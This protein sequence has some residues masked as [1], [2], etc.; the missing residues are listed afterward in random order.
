MMSYT[1]K[2]SFT[3]NIS[4]RFHYVTFAIKSQST[5][6]KRL[7]AS[8]GDIRNAYRILVGKLTKTDHLVSQGEK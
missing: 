8:M 2:P 3:K 6:W 7:V 4:E 1:L 5:A